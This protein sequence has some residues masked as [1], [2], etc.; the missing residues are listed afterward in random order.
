MLKLEVGHIDTATEH[1]LNHSGEDSEFLCIVISTN[2]YRVVHIEA[3]SYTV[4]HSID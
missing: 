2:I 1:F 4:T 3:P